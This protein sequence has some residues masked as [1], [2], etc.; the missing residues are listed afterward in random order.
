MLYMH[1]SSESRVVG[2]IRLR[3][4]ETDYNQLS[5]QSFKESYKLTQFKVREIEADG[6]AL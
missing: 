2:K 5:S 3:Y 4:K 1:I 6:G